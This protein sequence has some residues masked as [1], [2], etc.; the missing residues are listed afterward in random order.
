MKIQQIQ[1]N[2]T[3]F[4]GLHIDKRARKYLENSSLLSNSNIKECADKFE[5]VIKGEKV[6]TNEKLRV[7]DLVSCAGFSALFGVIGSIVATIGA[8]VASLPFINARTGMPS[9][10]PLIGSIFGFLGGAG[11]IIKDMLESL[12]K[13]D[14]SLQVGKNV[15]KS[16]FGKTEL[17]T[18]ISKKYQI[19]RESFDNFANLIQIAKQNDQRQF[20]NDVRKYEKNGI[21]EPRE[22]LKILNDDEIKQ[23]YK[24]GECF[25]YKLEN[26]SND[27][28]LTKFL[29]IVPT[30]ENEKDY[31]EIIK[32]MRKTKNIDYKQ[33]DSNGI[34]V[35]EKIINSENSDLLDLVKETEFDYSKELDCAYERIDNTEF[36]NRVKNLKVNFPNIKEA[37]R[38]NSQ[39]ALQKLLPELKSPFC[40]VKTMVNNLSENVGFD[41]LS[42]FISFCEDNGIDTSDIIL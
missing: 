17:E 21:Y 26:N 13:I 2:N 40:N 16:S 28:M 41:N 5:V 19:S 18:P 39:Q 8:M 35:I 20:I 3:N 33:V 31:Q 27:T 4:Q 37:V 25:N 11:F 15:K 42:N 14:Y 29:D 7:G 12:S 34:S 6:K 9:T 23:N 32:F 1:N 38:L 22:L 36:K 30:K 24:N 10:V